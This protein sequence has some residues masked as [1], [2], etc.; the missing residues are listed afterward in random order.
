VQ[1]AQQRGIK[2]FGQASD[3]ISAGPTSQLTASTDNWEP[4]Y[5]QRANAVIDGSWKSIDTWGGLNTGMLKMAPYTN[6]PDDVV[7][8][9]KQTEADIGSGKIV[10]FKGPI[11]DQ[12]GAVKVA[13]GSVL[14]D[15]AVAGMDWLADG[16]EGSLSK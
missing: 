14:D 12:N 4:Y 2:S 10:I 9:A 7:A 13:D 1:V 6:M 11:K 8:L 3:M 16:V 15:G 5:V